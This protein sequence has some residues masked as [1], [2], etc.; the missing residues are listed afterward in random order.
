MPA[1]VSRVLRETAKT[2]TQESE[3]CG[4]VWRLIGEILV[5]AGHEID[6]I[7]AHN[8]SRE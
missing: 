6:D 2:Y 4:Q 8:N 1:E 5:Q 3:S 7:V